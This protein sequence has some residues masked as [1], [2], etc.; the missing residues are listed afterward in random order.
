MSSCKPREVDTRATASAIA[1]AYFRERWLNLEQFA[2]LTI[3]PGLLWQQ[4]AFRSMVRTK[5][6]CEN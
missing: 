3:A 5:V 2:R 6:Y 1:L 4:S